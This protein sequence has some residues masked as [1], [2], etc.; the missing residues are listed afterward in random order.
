MP[1]YLKKINTSVTHKQNC[2]L[3]QSGFCSVGHNV[4]FDC[5]VSKCIESYVESVYMVI[6]LLCYFAASCSTVQL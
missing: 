5:I 2:V 3:T 1:F 6:G 4:D